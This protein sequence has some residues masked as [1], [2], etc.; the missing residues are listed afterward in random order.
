M[1]KV[2]SPGG[3]T[4]GPGNLKRKY[5][6]SSTPSGSADGALVED[7][8][9]SAEA[10]AAAAAAAAGVAGDKR[11]GYDSGAEYSHHCQF[12][13]ILNEFSMHFQ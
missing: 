12:R 1:G 3:P 8:S 4:G 9:A 13:L 11:G 10:A 6:S 5:W 7:A 2:Q